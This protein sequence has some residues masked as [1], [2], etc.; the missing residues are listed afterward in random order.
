[1]YV[2]VSICVY[3]LSVCIYVFI[4][5]CM[6]VCIGKAVVTSLDCPAHMG[7]TVIKRHQVLACTGS[8]NIS[9]NRLTCV[10]ACL[11][12]GALRPE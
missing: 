9:P 6:S 3:A 11:D 10:V 2:F 4:H 12:L 8:L 5:G 7:N 1:M